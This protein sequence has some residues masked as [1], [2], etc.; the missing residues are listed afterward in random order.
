[1]ALWTEAAVWK[2]VDS[3]DPTRPG[4]SQSG[5]QYTEQCGDKTD[6]VLPGVDLSG[7]GSMQQ[8]WIPSFTILS[9]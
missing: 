5:Q 2:E 8:S 3:L 6:G 4:Q 1:M 9:C 7:Q